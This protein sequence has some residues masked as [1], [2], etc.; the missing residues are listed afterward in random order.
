MLIRDIMTPRPITIRPDSDYLAA[1]AIMR[2]GNFRHLPVV[3]QDKKLVGIVSYEDLRATKSNMEESTRQQAILSD[4][5]LIRVASVM[6]ENVITCPPDFPVEEAACL[7]IK[8]KVSCLPVLDE[9]QLVGIITDIDVFRVF[10]DVLGGGSP[11]IRVSVQMDN[12]PG[13]IAALAQQVARISGNISSIASYPADKPDRL[14]IM[15]RIENVDL[16]TLVDAIN[17][18]PGAEIRYTWDQTTTC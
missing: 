14:N 9:G 1:I 16:S 6:K 7:M 13:Q 5:V 8:H 3:D 2:A 12:R 11:T 4:G 17:Q 18:H 10:V 15:L